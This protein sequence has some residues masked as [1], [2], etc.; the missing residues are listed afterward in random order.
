ME[1]LVPVHMARG[2]LWDTWIPLKSTVLCIH[3]MIQVILQN[4]ISKVKSESGQNKDVKLPV[5]FSLFFLN[6]IHQFS[7]TGRKM[8][9]HQIKA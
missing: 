7:F 8:V 2:Y 3:H 1:P 6:N 5:I 9:D 4:F